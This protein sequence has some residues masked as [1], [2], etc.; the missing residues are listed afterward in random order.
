MANYFLIIFMALPTGKLIEVERYSYN[1]IE[2][3][4]AHSTLILQEHKH[5]HPTEF[6][7]A[8][9][10]RGDLEEYVKHNVTGI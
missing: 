7:S 2:E 9:C 8:S 4:V 10:K 6:M 3:C 1:N 5:K